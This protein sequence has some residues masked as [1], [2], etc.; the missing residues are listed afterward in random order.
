MSNGDNFF[1]AGRSFCLFCFT[2][3]YLETTQLGYIAHNIHDCIFMMSSGYLYI[4]VYRE[5]IEYYEVF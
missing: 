2:S 5:N 4:N 3:L 1:L